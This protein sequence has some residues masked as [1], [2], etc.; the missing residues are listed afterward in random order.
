MP[1]FEYH[2]PNC[3]KDFEKLILRRDE[4][5]TCP[6]CGRTEVQQKLSVTAFKTDYHGFM[7]TPS[8]GYKQKGVVYPPFETPGAEKNRQ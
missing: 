3:G 5:V 8:S 4:A 7:S 1:I 2:C 6:D